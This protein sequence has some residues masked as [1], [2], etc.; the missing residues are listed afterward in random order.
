MADHNE[1][2]K[3]GEEMA[4][5][6]LTDKGYNILRR[7]YRFKKLELDIIAQQDEEIVVVEV[8]TR[9]SDYLTDPTELL[10][11]K[12]Q[13]DI[14]RAADY[15]INEEEIDL[16]CRFD[17]IIIVVNQHQK[18]IRHIEDAFYPGLN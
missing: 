4:V 9:Q 1:L 13:S 7:N 5:K 8:K 18:E 12:K 6:F 11:R 17:V 2:G 3:I 10:S 14:I 16:E 15:F